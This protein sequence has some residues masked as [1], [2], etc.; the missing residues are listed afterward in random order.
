MN[1][2]MGAIVVMI[3][4]GYFV[5]AEVRMIQSVLLVSMDMTFNMVRN[6]QKYRAWG[7]RT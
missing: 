1:M 6:F 7:D 2:R 4:F 5:F 3:F